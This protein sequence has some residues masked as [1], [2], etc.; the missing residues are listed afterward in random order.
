MLIASTLLALYHTGVEHGVI[1]HES[2]C[3]TGFSNV[4]TFED[5]KRTLEGKNI[6]SCDH[7][8]FHFIGLSFVNWSLIFVCS[9]LISTLM[10]AYK[11]GEFKHIE[12]TNSN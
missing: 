2:V 5:Y 3:T 11:F 1:K 12:T 4:K 8:L 7:A 9:L 6:V 10:T